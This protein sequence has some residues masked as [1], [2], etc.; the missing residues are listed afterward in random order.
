MQVDEKSREV[1]DLKYRV[2]KE[3]FQMKLKEE[4]VMQAR[5]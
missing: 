3:E 5:D 1:I 2:E 4:N